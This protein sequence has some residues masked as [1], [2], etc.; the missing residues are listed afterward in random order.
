MGDPLRDLPAGHGLDNLP[1][2]VGPGLGES[3]LGGG[4]LGPA[5]AV[6]GQGGQE[7]GVTARGVMEIRDGLDEAFPGEVGE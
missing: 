5:M 1:D 6:L 4:F 3:D 7:G 2:F